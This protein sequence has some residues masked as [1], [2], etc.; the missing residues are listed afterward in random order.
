MEQKTTPKRNTPGT[1]ITGD[2]SVNWEEYRDWCLSSPAAD[3]R[4][5]SSNKKVQMQN[6]KGFETF[7][8]HLSPHKESVQYGGINTCKYAVP[9]CIQ[10]C[11][12]RTGHHQM[13]HAKKRRIE[14]TL[15]FDRDCTTFDERLRLEIE[16][17]IRRVE[18]KGL[19]LALRLDGVSDLGLGEHYRWIYPQVVF[20]DYTKDFPRMAQW[21]YDT[22][23]G[24]ASNYHL[25][26]S[27]SGEN[28]VECLQ[29]LK[30]GG[31]I[32][33]PLSHGAPEDL[34]EMWGWDFL[35]G[36]DDDR[37][38]LDPSLRGTIIGLKWKGSKKRMKYAIKKKFCIDTWDERNF[39]NSPWG[40]MAGH[41]VH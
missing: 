8:M 28:S 21:I 36:T 31:N 10:G 34:R 17:A 3:Y 29:V 20:Y 5:L 30:R 25:T 41:R 35:D 13:R 16:H 27:W 1:S 9:A 12:S 24:K 19:D 6:G 7:C 14:R 33:I 37:R 22:V 23:R 15:W 11:I 40:V 2:T 26:F 38:F 4:L 18:R 39:V 32:A